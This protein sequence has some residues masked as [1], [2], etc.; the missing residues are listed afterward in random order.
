M[1][2]FAA[3]YPSYDSVLPAR[4]SQGLRR[5]TQVRDDSV[6]A[7]SLSRFNGAVIPGRCVGIEPGMTTVLVAAMNALCG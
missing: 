4:L 3:L 5:S 2:G 6:I 1:M 7:A